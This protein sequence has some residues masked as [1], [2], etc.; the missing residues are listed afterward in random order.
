MLF[1]KSIFLF[2]KKSALFFLFFLASICGFSQV[3][4]TSSNAV[5]KALTFHLFD[6]ESGLSNNYING[7]EQD[8][9]GFIW[10]ATADGLNRYDG[11]K[12]IKF[13]N[14]KDKGL[15]DNNI[16][17]I[18]YNAQNKTLYIATDKGLSLYASKL[19]KFSPYSEKNDFLKNFVNSFVLDKK[20]NLIFSMLRK[21]EGLYFKD[22]N[23]NLST[24]KYHPKN[25]KSLSSNE[26]S[27][28][29][30]QND[31]TLW[32]G[33]YHG[34]LNKM[35]YAN[36][37]IIRVKNKRISKSINTIY[38]DKEQNTWIGTND[39]LHVI[40]S[41][42]DTLS[43]KASTIEKGLSDNN[44]LCFE[45]DNQ[46]RIWIG[47]RN[48]G[49]NIL[50]KSSLLNREKKI[51]IKWFLPKNDG[52]SVF[53]RTVSCLKKDKNNNMWIGTST[54]LNFVNPKEEPVKL[55]Q[56]DITNPQSISHDRIG[57]LAL[58]E[59]FKIWI[60]T[61]GGGL[62]LLDTKNGTFTYYK[63][64]E[65]NTNSLSNNYIISLLEDSK[66]RVWVGTYQG[67]LNLLN[68]STGNTKKYISRADI[69]IIF[70]DGAQK[71]WVGTNRDGLFNYNEKN[72]TFDYVKTLGK[73][74]IRD[75][76]KGQNQQLW[77]ATYGDGIINYNTLTGKALFYTLDNIKGLQ[78][79][80]FFSILPLANGD[81]LLGSRYSGLIRFNPVTKKIS[82]FTEDNGL[83]NNTIVSILQENEQFVWLGT[84][85]GINRFN[86]NNNKVSDLSFLNNIQTS[87]FNIG[88]ALK[89]Q[90]GHLYFGGNKG[91][92]IFYPKRLKK[93]HN[94]YKL[95]FTNFLIFNNPVAIKP[96]G[97]NSIL[98]QSIAY[99][100]QIQ[101]NYDHTLF[102]IGFSVLKYP[103]AKNISY[104]YLL[105]GYHDHWI[106][107]KGEGLANFSH[108]PPGNYI[109]KVKAFLD[110]GVE[111]STE[112]KIN[113]SP[114][115]WK[116]VPAYM[117]Y[118]LFIAAVIFFAMKYYSERVKLRNSLLFEKK[119]RQ[120][121]HDLNEERI[122]FFTNFSHELK[123]PLTLIL[124]PLDDLIE[125]LKKER[126]L[127]NA[128]L[129]KKNAEI[130]YQ[131]INK[132]LQFRKSETGLSQLI[133][134][135]HNLTQLLEQTVLNFSS[136]AKSMK[137]NL[138]LL[139][140][141][142]EVIIGID[143]E[144]FQII[145]N[146]LISNA[147]KYCNEKGEIKIILTTFD[148]LVKIDV[149]D[150]GTGIDTN[151]LPYIFDWY[152]QSGKS[153]KKKGTGIG[154]AL[155]KSFIEL[156]GGTIKVENNTNSSGVTF[157]VQLPKN[158][159]IATDVSQYNLKDKDIDN[160]WGSSD[161]KIATEE[162]QKQIKLKQ[163][164]KLILLVDDNLD[165]IQYLES[166]LKN[167]YDL[168]FAYNGNDGIEK[169]IKY[170][171][172]IIISDIM[173]PQKT[174][175]ELCHYLKNQMSTTH[176]PIILL[177]AKNNNDSI[178][179][180]Y[181]EGADDY[182]TKPFNGEILK[183][184]IQ[185]LLKSRDKLREYF[186][187]Q[188]PAVSELSSDNLKIIDKEKIFLSKLKSIILKNL[189]NEN[190]NV[191]SIAKDIGM[192]RS[193]LYRKI[194]AI[195]GKNINDF[196]RI[197]RLEKAA[198][199]LKNEEMS[200]AEVSYEVGFN[201][202]NYFREIFKS[203]YGMLPSDYKKG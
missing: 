109:L 141:Q 63:H 90:N 131:N 110:S 86:I 88:V 81:L 158:D 102:T 77:I 10:V 125:N 101:L 123:T 69:R 162:K 132:L 203:E 68:K 178:K 187:L 2:K 147:L 107:V 183:T 192:S 66:N 54:G 1:I 45:E 62:D 127:K 24:F 146:N 181:L 37:T 19:E 136:L 32:I 3:I 55:L 105:E 80:V 154:L 151:D 143:V 164:R 161:I 188:E 150:T 170:I 115:F 193:S 59:N 53:N 49:L 191:D 12:F 138:A 202:V 34:G 61:D 120:L 155:T 93:E 74:D 111:L 17:Q 197:V 182:V 60:G 85:N 91:L 174:G 124:A 157:S 96:E 173:M 117:L 78:T 100:D 134:E 18:K 122:H 171:P 94:D 168:I 99:A 41:K 180:G 126:H 135:K 28:L 35:D 29:A 176:I 112:L 4:N 152:Y 87:E 142:E 189:K 199:L 119:Q 56:N 130:L 70:E 186:T 166:M 5:D 6:V 177:T 15:V 27:C 114:P 14:T 156:H 44:V 153:P 145:I 159:Q 58:S 194:T 51:A 104:S 97:K 72:D 95:V 8:S 133:L 71:I 103:E 116:T 30:L 129:V 39:G 92:N 160:L 184:R 48:G 149:K 140:P 65:K 98:D 169:A 40:T 185:N 200:I 201:S 89:D 11:T 25:E 108:T 43:L 79:N 36:K 82:T 16:A 128:R 20:G 57:A 165:I 47:T 175:I 46:G 195:T 163:N 22:K 23:G 106:K 26:I 137:I 118:V 13:R 7:I 113:I 64:S 73:I 38:V 42:K 84:T 76:K 179:S 31:K 83:S 196:I 75:I 144:K 172:D 139:T 50:N 21:Q 167:Q 190:L 198:Y 33:T 52:S 121:E 148:D 67:G 9:L